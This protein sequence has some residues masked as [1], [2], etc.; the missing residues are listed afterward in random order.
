MQAL[1][2]NNE[3]LFIVFEK[4]GFDQYRK[5]KAKAIEHRVPFGLGAL[6]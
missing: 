5:I 6:V 4:T 3:A 1:A 2:D